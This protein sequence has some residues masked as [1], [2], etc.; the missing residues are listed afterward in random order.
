[1]KFTFP[2]F[3]KSGDLA[4]GNQKIMKSLIKKEIGASVFGNIAQ[5]DLTKKP[6]YG[7][8]QDVV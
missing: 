5:N 6:V 4:N 7:K 1:M 8:I 2:L 3:Q